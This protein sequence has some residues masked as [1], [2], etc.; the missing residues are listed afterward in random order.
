MWLKYNPK[1]IECIENIE[2]II[3]H[4]N[5]NLY[6]IALKYKTSTPFISNDLKI[7]NYTIKYRDSG[8]N[9]LHKKK[10][11]QKTLRTRY[12]GDNLQEWYQVKNDVIPVKELF[13]IEKFER[14]IK[15]RK[16]GTWYFKRER[17]SNQNNEI[18]NNV[19]HRNGGI[20]V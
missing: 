18:V 15:I 16:D 6:E 4:C 11:M 17:K 8:W 14:P 19:V 1:I 13:D 12:I 5:H 10:C 3:H 9:Y 7:M 2:N 20:V